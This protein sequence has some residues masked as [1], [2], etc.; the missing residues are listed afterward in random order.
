MAL[1][2][3][4]VLADLLEP[5]RDELQPRDGVGF[6]I[7]RKEEGLVRRPQVRRGLELT[8]QDL[9]KDLIRELVPA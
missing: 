4:V 8:V 1:P 3:L 7:W 5:S 2:K 9:E 6:E